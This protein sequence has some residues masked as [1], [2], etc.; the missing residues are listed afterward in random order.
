MMDV[1]KDSGIATSAFVGHNLVEYTLTKDVTTYTE[2]SVGL[3]ND[4]SRG[5]KSI[6]VQDNG[7]IHT[8]LKIDM[9]GGNP[10]HS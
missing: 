3:R 4:D 9:F 7:P 10:N 6:L 2:V 8:S 5:E 1:D